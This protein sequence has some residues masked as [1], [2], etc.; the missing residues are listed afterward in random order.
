MIKIILNLFFF[1]ILRILSAC[2]TDIS[3]SNQSEVTTWLG[4]NSNFSKVYIEGKCVL[5][6]VLIDLPLEQKRV[7]AN[8]IAKS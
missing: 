3:K 5:D 7:V 2:V 6:K 4:S 1:G 8:L